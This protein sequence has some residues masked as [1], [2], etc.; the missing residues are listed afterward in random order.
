MHE[1]SLQ[2][3]EI[4]RGNLSACINIKKENKEWL[5]TDELS[6]MFQV[7]FQMMNANDAVNTNGLL[8]E[9]A[10]LQRHRRIFFPKGSWVSNAEFGRHRKLPWGK[11]KLFIAPS[12]SSH[13]SSPHLSPLTSRRETVKKLWRNYLSNFIARQISRRFL[14]FHSLQFL[15]VSRAASMLCADNVIWNGFMSL[16]CW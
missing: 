13:P 12:R 10:D 2:K 5:D 14:H 16:L 9:C 8:S 1:T 7:L 6:F 15:W 4:V 11:S 3:E